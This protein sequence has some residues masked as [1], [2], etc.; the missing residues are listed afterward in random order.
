MANGFDSDVDHGA[1]DLD[2]VDRQLAVLD[3]PEE[4]STDRAAKILGCCKHTVLQYQA[5]GLLEWRNA[6]PPSSARPVFRFTLRSVLK[7]RLDYQ[8]GSARSPL[9]VTPKRSP[10]RPARG[11]GYEPKHLRRKTSTTDRAPM[12][13]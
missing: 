3:L 8:K 7:L 2:K 1:A 10:T 12:S 5:D 11:E 13:E 9:P 6:A 4:V